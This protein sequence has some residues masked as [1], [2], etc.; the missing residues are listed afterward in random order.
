M[1][2]SNDTMIDR[3]SAYG[4]GLFE[5][6]AIRDGEAR[7]WGTHMARL[8]MSCEK[9]GIACPSETEIRTRFES[10]LSN[11][12]VDLTFA[13]ARLVVAAGK[14]KRGYRRDP[15]SEP[16]LSF[17]LFPA[18]PL[19]KEYASGGV[20]VRKCK[21]RL[22]EQPALAGMKTLNRLEQVLARSEWEDPQIFEGILLD[23][24]DRLICGTM[25]NVFT[26]INSEI[27]TPALDRCGV[28]G[29]MRSHVMRLLQEHGTNISE[30]D[31][32]V[33]ELSDASEL[34][35]TN[36]QF[37]VLPIRALDE[38]TTAIGPMTRRAQSL[39]AATGVPECSP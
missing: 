26:V 27:C 8:Q 7:F 14:S 2:A 15:D 19:P 16:E 39:V 22:A 12:D 36:S 20:V 21:L 5:T 28:A 37:G 29:T 35:L 18:T 31:I 3:A 13:T 1:T 4:D 17:D 9:L 33:N 34:F 10:A 38:A 24:S 11:G 6:I 23:T 32:S 25:S 30:R